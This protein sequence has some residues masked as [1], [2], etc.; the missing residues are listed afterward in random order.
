MSVDEEK[1][2]KEGKSSKQSKKSIRKRLGLE[3]KSGKQKEGKSSKSKSSDGNKTN[4][5]DQS[6]GN[7]STSSISTKNDDDSGI[8]LIDVNDSLA[9]D[10]A[11]PP[12]TSAASIATTSS[13]KKKDRVDRVSREAR[14]MGK[15]V[16]KRV[17]SLSRSRSSRR[18][19][20][21]DS[22]TDTDHSSSSDGGSGRRPKSTVVTVTSCRS[23]GYYNQK[24]PGSTSKLPR[25][26]PTNLKLFHELAVGLKDAFTAVGQ[27]PAK[28]VLEQEITDE[29]T[30]E[31]QMVQVM[32]EEEFAGRNVLWDFMG[33]IDF[34]LALVD[35]VAVDTA[36]RGALKD[37]TT[38]K[39]LRDVI[40]KCNKVLE[41]ML[42]RRERRYTLFF[43]LPQP[44]DSRDMD[45]IRSWNEKVE[46]AVGAVTENNKSQEFTSNNAQSA[47]D[48]DSDASSMTG[49]STVSAASSKQSLIQRGRQLLPVAGRVRSRRATPTPKLR[50]RASTKSKDKDNSENAAEDGFAAAS[51]ITQGNLAALQRSFQ[52]PSGGS[53]PIAI[54]DGDSS[55]SAVK[56]YQ[57]QPQQQLLSQAP[58]IQPKD[59]LVDVIRGLRLE[60]IQHRE[61]NIDNDLTALKP[62]W[63]PKAEIPSSVPK[64]PNEYIHRHKLMKQVVSC[65]LEQTGAGPRD[66][67]EESP[68]EQ[69]AIVT[70][71]TSRHGDKAGNGK[72]ILAVAAIQTVE[73]RERFTD[74]IAW[75]HLGRGPLSER[76][77]RRLY[78]E[79][80]RQL[81]VKVPDDFFGDGDFLE[82]DDDI[83]GGKIGE[84]PS[85]SSFDG[86]ESSKSFGRSNLK[87]ENKRHRLATLAESRQRFQGGDLESIKEDFARLLV[88]KR[89]L[90]CLDDVW[91]VQDAKWFI[92]DN[93]INNGSAKPK[94]KKR[95]DLLD[96]DEY[97]SRVLMTTRTPG[98]LGAGLVQEVFV[99]ILSETEAV[100]LLL[101]TAG[102]RPY[103]GKNSTVFHQSKLVVKG[104]GN[105]PLAV[106]VSG[107]MLRHSSRSWTIKSPS[108]S[109]LLHQCRLNLEEASQLRS[110][111]NAVNRV[112]DLSFFTVADVHTRVALRRCFV[113]FAMAFRDNDWMLS[114]R[115]VPH[116]VVLRVFKT[117]LHSD[118]VTK[119]I[120][121]GA[122]LTM[123]QNLNL[124]GH[125]R[126]GVAS[127]ALTA[128]QKLSIA[129]KKSRSSNEN[130]S[131]SD[132]D[133]EDEAQI[134]KAQQSWV[135][136]E[137]LKSVA[138]EMAK[139]STFCL[140]PE[141]DDF[142]SF[143][144]KIEEERMMISE[145]STLWAKPLRFFTQQLSHG[146]Q[147][148][149]GFQDN[150]TYKIVM[151]S[152]L[153]VGDG[154]TSSNSIVDTLREGQIDVAVIPGGEKME[155]YI[156]T[157]FPGHLMRCEVFAYAAELLSDPHFIAR[158]A[159]ALGIIEATSR[160]VADLQELRRLAG[161]ITLTINRR[162]GKEA[163]GEKAVPTKV[164]INSIVREGSR[165]IID[166]ISRVAVR[167]GNKPDLLGQAMCYAAVGEGLT[168]SRQPRDGMA[169]LDEAVN[170]YKEL[171]GPF[172]VKVADA[173]Q[174][175][176]KAL[177]KLGEPR[178]A[179]LKFAEA[180]RIYESCGATLHYNSIA[181]AQSLASLLVDLGDMEKAQSMFEEVISMRKTVYGEHCVQVAK[182][183]N[184]YAILLA[185]HGKMNVALENYETA[186]GTY[187]NVPIPSIRDPEF[188]IKCKYDVTLIN[189]NIASIRSK[190]GDLREAITCYEDGV[191]GLRQYE[192][193]LAELQKDPLRPPETGKNTAH[194]HLVAALGRIGSLKL[195]IGDSNGA[196]LAYTSLL[197]EVKSDSP[198]ASQTEKA[199]A[200]IKCATIYRQQNG[201][202]AHQLSVSHLQ[203][204]LDMYKAIFGPDHKDTMA[205]SSSLKQWL[206]EDQKKQKIAAQ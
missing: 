102:R 170:L 134:H 194:K 82:S 84:V 179:L 24:A 121:P 69:N 15:G 125:A 33:N 25:K 32:S 71:I 184:A 73:V 6:S 103:G 152:L 36:T 86:A 146:E 14:R 178:V 173:L 183:I 58:I 201:T 34:L 206:A 20:R 177:V 149:T 122:I 160:Q 98:L 104:C 90:I 114:G 137:S 188:E 119:D 3:K 138:E 75:I 79:L 181:N 175:S 78:E 17:R 93:H 130:D 64:L 2:V 182:T 153:E 110:F 166:E 129:R 140:S 68:N 1:E 185:K 133:D 112:V 128:A 77:I 5:I 43:R 120:S 47:S 116:S 37:D 97:P 131:D 80:Y 202:D 55:N 8:K 85:G 62:D 96:D 26:A 150:E 72:T 21:F 157:F 92:F 139:R 46:R 70:S 159:N 13:E 204:A 165:I 9:S 195:K 27:T 196:L 135:M 49:A 88:K 115:G 151:T 191:S 83:D 95:S 141:A 155:E 108:W 59:E 35:E 18:K 53:A 200:H 143:C 107:S 12:M 106:R 176:A 171:V 44:L 29:A 94:K 118:E 54:Q 172:N 61:S 154:I 113:A 60:K 168:K 174:T 105:S 66:V 187:M 189:L 40:K 161:N 164:D 190:K 22:D 28:P 87:D 123:L 7:F 192:V 67:D 76:D 99:R 144:E 31:T 124:M 169:R 16:M 148:L 126:H 109:A 19:D 186:K 81:I 199:K 4:N 10:A 198:S 89:V 203:Q 193:A 197:E 39:G 51:P 91:R 147:A 50:K 45:R 127:R 167:N 156:V 117:I 65:L 163:T 145:S 23:D 52:K 205:I 180:A 100:K 38:F 30:G 57:T 162:P 74:G 48:S 63:R 111:V 136:H 56:E 132:W 101:S 41:E 42:V 142:T 158:R 11:N